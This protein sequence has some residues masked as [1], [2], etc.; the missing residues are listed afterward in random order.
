MVEC[1]EVWKQSEA[2]EEVRGKGGKKLR[3]GKSER[4]RVP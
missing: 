4:A 1:L 2:G 3:C